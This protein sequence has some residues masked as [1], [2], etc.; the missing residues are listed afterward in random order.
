MHVLLS[1]ISDLA[2]DWYNVNA[3]GQWEANI[4]PEA[5]FYR[6]F[7]NYHRLRLTPLVR[8][9]RG[10]TIQ[11]DDIITLCRTHGYNGFTL[12]FNTMPNEAWFDMMDQALNIPG[13]DLIAVEQTAPGFPATVRGIA[14]SSTLFPQAHKANPASMIPC[15]DME[16][17]TNAVPQLDE[18]NPAI[19]VF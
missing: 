8:V 19:L 13:I 11:P 7:A 17:T 15:S 2:P 1:Y 14:G 5:D 6:I 4:N 10:A 12:L 18:H 16:S 9:D 3:D